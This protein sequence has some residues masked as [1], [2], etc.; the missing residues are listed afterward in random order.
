[1]S[2]AINLNA[3]DRAMVAHAAAARDGKAFPGSETSRTAVRS[4]PSSAKPSSRQSGTADF[5]SYDAF[6][7]HGKS[8]SRWSVGWK[9][10][11]SFVEIAACQPGDWLHLKWGPKEYDFRETGARLEADARQ[12]AAQEAIHARDGKFKRRRAEQICRQQRQ[13]GSGQPWR[14][15]GHGGHRAGPRH[16]PGCRQKCVPGGKSSGGLFSD[17]LP[18]EATESD[19]RRSA[20]GQA[21]I[22][23]KSRRPASAQPLRRQAPSVS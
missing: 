2:L 19:I 4:R 10:P 22:S 18:L 16:L 6:L 15:C 3:K 1:M 5:Y 8:T 11:R 14:P 12:A 21:Q 9:V 7:G 13:T 20:G 17:V 23:Q